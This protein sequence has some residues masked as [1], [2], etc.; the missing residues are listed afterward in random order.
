[1]ALR[2]SL[3]FTAT[4]T[5]LMIAWYL[6]AYMY[7]WTLAD[8]STGGLAP[9]S[10]W[11]REAMSVAAAIVHA[12]DFLMGLGKGS[13]DVGEVSLRF[14][15]WDIVPAVA[16]ALLI[17][18]VASAAALGVGEHLGTT[19][20]VSFGAVVLASGLAYLASMAVQ[21][22]DLDLPPV[23]GEYRFPPDE[24][25]TFGIA[26]ALAATAF[27]VFLELVARQSARPAVDAHF[28]TPNR[29]VATWAILPILCVGIIGGFKWDY[30][31]EEQYGGNGGSDPTQSTYQGLDL[32]MRLLGY[33]R[34]R[35]NAPH[36]PSALVDSVAT[37]VWLP[38]TI[39]SICLV[40]LLWFVIRWLGHRFDRSPVSVVHQVFGCWAAITAASVA[41]ALIEG[42]ARFHHLSAVELELGVTTA[43]KTLDTLRDAACFGAGVGWAGALAMVIARRHLTT[44]ALLDGDEDRR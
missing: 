28:R 25:I 44:S 1:M 9:E 41:V 2:R 38:R 17:P 13:L 5:A 6:L 16:L 21:S 7:A 27:F 15:Q 36:H 26:L 32:V 37:D 33:L 24:M 14:A 22:I 4:V 34:I 35:P 18:I 31:V 23:K 29:T 19:A 42:I 10:R 12:P 39:A 43:H 40:I 8:V 20:V 30:P 3:I 11:R